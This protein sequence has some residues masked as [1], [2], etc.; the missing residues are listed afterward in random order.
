MSYAVLFCYLCGRT[1][2]LV[3]HVSGSSGEEVSA[4]PLLPHPV[5]A[6]LVAHALAGLPPADTS[7]R[8]GLVVLRDSRDSE[9]VPK[10]SGN[11]MENYTSD[12]SHRI[13]SQD[14]NS[15]LQFCSIKLIL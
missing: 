5:L 13:F 7:A 9:T 12:K 15:R 2:G 8:R 10:A 11:I 14:V 1:T 6:V 3:P 4:P